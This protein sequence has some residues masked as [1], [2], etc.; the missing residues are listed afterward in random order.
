VAVS[1]GGVVNYRIVRMWRFPGNIVAILMLALLT[2]RAV[3]ADK[4]VVATDSGNLIQ[5]NNGL[6]GITLDKRSGDL[7]SIRCLTRDPPLELGNG[8]N[9]MYFD[10]D[11]TNGHQHPADANAATLIHS[12]AE[13]A[14]AVVPCQASEKF[15]FH[16]EVHYILRRGISGF[17]VYVLYK[18]GPGMG[19]VDLGQTR[20]VVRTA[21]GEKIFTNHIVDD[22]RM[23]TF[24]T[25]KE[26]ETLQDTTWRFDDGRIYTKYDNC[27]FIGDD[28]VYGMAGHGV[29]MWMV[30][31]SREY[32][33]GGPLRQE[34]TV[35]L[36]GILLWMLQGGH[37]GG[38]DIELTDGQPWTRFYGPAMVYIN[39]G[40][41]LEDM[42]HDAQR[43]AQVQQDQWPYRFINSED[44]PLARGTVRGTVRLTDGSSAKD[45]WVVLAYPGDKDWCQSSLGY[46]FWTKADEQGRFSLTNVRPGEYCLFVSGANQFEDFRQDHV[47]VAANA[48]T[49][50]GTLDWQPVTHG[51]TLWQIGVA[52]RSTREFKGGDDV[53][54][55][56]NFIRYGKDFPDDVTFVIGKSDPARDWNFAQWGWYM[57]RPYWRIQFDEPA[58]LSGNATLTLGFASW[59]YPHG[60]VVKVNGQAVG[61]TIKLKKSGAAGYR[62]GG[63][64]SLYQLVYVP[65]DAGLIKAG[66][67]E[68]TLGLVGAVPFADPDAARPGRIGDVMYDAIRLE[69]DSK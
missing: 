49:E 16:T 12:D 67:N 64:D 55:Y 26:V 60:L 54:H 22:Q 2:A 8:K 44:Y 10:F 48:T 66:T 62:S 27:A 63:Q 41:S 11:G 15:P 13:S 50:L 29:G 58:A 32:V 65:F 17:Y 7:N 57:K 28:I 20:T 35:H 33:N 42:W 69:V 24:P 23:G 31:P 4:P 34:L 47:K 6:V 43:Q 52:D 56:S 3:G 25:G 39:Q 21:P 51:K 53:R 14:E 40:N 38:A 18:H 9:A 1:G 46:M 61:E 30:Q 36:D 5:M 19:A 45:A 37:F 68:I 59:N